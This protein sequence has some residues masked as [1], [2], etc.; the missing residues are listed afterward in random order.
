MKGKVENQQKIVENLIL[1]KSTL[2]GPQ[3][4]EKIEALKVAHI[5][6]IRVINHYNQLKSDFESKYPEKGAALGRVYKKN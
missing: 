5:E 1:Q 4:T 6:L 2:K 3:L